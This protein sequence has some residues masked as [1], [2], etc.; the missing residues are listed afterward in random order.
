MCGL[1]SRFVFFAAWKHSCHVGMEHG[2]CFSAVFGTGCGDVFC[3]V[4]PGS[5]FVPGLVPAAWTGSHGL[6]GA[7]CGKLKRD[8]PLGI[9]FECGPALA[10][11]TVSCVPAEG[12]PSRTS[13][14]LVW[15]RCGCCSEHLGLSCGSRHDVVGADS[16]SPRPGLATG[17]G[18]SCGRPPAAW[19]AVRAQLPGRFWR[20]VWS[21][22]WQGSGSRSQRLQLVPVSSHHVLGAADMCPAPQMDVSGWYPA[23]PPA[24]WAGR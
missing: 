1:S 16:G 18:F 13:A 20:T 22:V 10:A 9:G 8:A 15:P 11:W 12:K 17:S 19:D 21:P 5:G 14:V 6:L 2:G 24:L 7:G 4:G 3:D 23:Q